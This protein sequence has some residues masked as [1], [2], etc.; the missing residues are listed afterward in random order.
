MADKIH[1]MFNGRQVEADPTM[2]LQQLMELQK[3][4]RPEP[5]THEHTHDAR[6]DPVLCEMGIHHY[7][8]ELPMPE[9]GMT[10]DHEQ[11]FEYLADLIQIY[12]RWP[13]EAR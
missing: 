8:I 5:A 4:S 7:T 11:L 6:H 12:A 9:H 13:V 3:Q 2:T 1:V 10:V